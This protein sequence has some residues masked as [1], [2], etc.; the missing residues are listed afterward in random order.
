MKADKIPNNPKL[1]FHTDK[2]HRAMSEDQVSDSLDNWDLS[3]SVYV[4]YDEYD[5]QKIDILVRAAYKEFGTRMVD[6]YYSY[7][8]PAK[9]DPP[10]S[11]RACFRFRNPY[12]ATM[13]ALKYIK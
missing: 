1:G 4:Y 6:W 7:I 8:P 5:R 12:D 11:W 9:D 10:N 13:F 2:G 3:E